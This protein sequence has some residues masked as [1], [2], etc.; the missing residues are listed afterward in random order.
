L[1]GRANHFVLLICALVCAAASL[2]SQLAAGRAAEDQPSKA[3]AVTGIPV[4]SDLRL[5]G[6]TKQTRFII[7]LDK[8]IFL[9]GSRSTIQRIKRNDKPANIIADWAPDLEKFRVMRQK[10]L[11]YH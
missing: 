10:Y 3:V 7:D 1:A 2:C 4:V 8:T 6:D 9:F 5:A 11:L